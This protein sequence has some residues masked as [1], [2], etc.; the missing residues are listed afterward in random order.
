[1]TLN[2]TGYI[3]ICRSC[4][5]TMNRMVMERPTYKEVWY[6]DADIFVCPDCH[7]PRRLALKR[8]I[9]PG[10]EVAYFAEEGKGYTTFTYALSEEEAKDLSVARGTPF[11]HKPEDDD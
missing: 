9:A 1:M 2:E 11:E 10:T 7:H 5:Q 4:G 3:P 8:G 6:F